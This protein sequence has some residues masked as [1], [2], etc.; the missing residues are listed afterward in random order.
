MRFEN[1]L[2]RPDPARPDPVRPDPTRPDPTRPDPAGPA[3]F[4]DI[5]IRSGGR[6]FTRESGPV[7]NH[8]GLCRSPAITIPRVRSLACLFPT[9]S[10]SLRQ[11]SAGASTSTVRPVRNGAGYRGGWVRCGGGEGGKGGRER[12]REGGRGRGR[13]RQADRKA[14]KKV[15]RISSQDRQA[16]NTL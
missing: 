16:Y 12:G 9:G 1:L 2:T 10:D 4:N 3:R 8:R 6:V 11:A 14:D 7:G 5:L 13:D 15:R